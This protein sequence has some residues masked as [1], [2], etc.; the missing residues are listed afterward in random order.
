MVGDGSKCGKRGLIQIV[1]D[2]RYEKRRKS[3]AEYA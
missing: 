1:R 2:M 3:H